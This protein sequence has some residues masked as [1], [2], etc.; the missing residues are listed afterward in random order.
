MPQAVTHILI[1]ILIVSLIRD[2][3]IRKKDKKYFPLHYVLIAGIGGVLPDIDI[4]FS[5][6]LNLSGSTTWNVHKTFTH[7]LFFPIILFALFLILKP[8]N[9]RTKI[10]NLGKHNL[11]LSIIMLM[12][13]LGVLI[14]IGLDSIFGE[15]A[16][17]FYPFSLQDYGVNILSY[18]PISLQGLVIPT[19]DG[20][21]LVIWLVYLELKHKISDFI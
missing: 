15:M 3:Y 13:S 16:Y 18:L 5:I 17:F 8:V 4:I 9:I 2:F 7:S 21:L 10:C 12:L 1:P 20:I 14:H 6:I 11:K 19:L